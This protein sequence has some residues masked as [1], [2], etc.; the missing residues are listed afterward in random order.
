MDDRW[1]VRIDLGRPGDAAAAFA[2]ARA[3]APAGPLAEDA[4][5]REAEALVQA[6]ARSDARARAAE[7]LRLYPRG[8]RGPALRV[9]GGP[10]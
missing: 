10:E 4:L 6:G 1:P 8:R 3:L 7:Y 9:L 5:A 2:R